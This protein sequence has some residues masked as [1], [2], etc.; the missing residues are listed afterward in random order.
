MHRVRMRKALLHSLYMTHKIFCPHHL[1]NCVLRHVQCSADFSLRTS[2]DEHRLGLDN[3]PWWNPQSLDIS[4][5]PYAIF[6][7]G[8]C[9]M[10]FFG[11]A[12]V[13]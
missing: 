2:L 7:V 6:A 5:R 13:L 1:R 11:G 12:S 9:C 8:C 3:F 10:R 4:A